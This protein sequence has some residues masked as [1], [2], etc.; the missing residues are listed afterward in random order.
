MTSTQLPGHLYGPA[1]PHIGFWHG[2]NFIGQVRGNA[3]DVEGAK[4]RLARHIRILENA[5]D[6]GRMLYQLENYTEAKIICGSSVTAIRAPSTSATLLR[7]LKDA[8]YIIDRR[9]DAG[10]QY[11]LMLVYDPLRDIV[12]GL[13][14]Q[15]GPAF[16]VGKLTFPGGKTEAGETPEEA[17]SR[18]TEEE[19]G[20]TVPVDAWRF[21]ARSSVVMVMAAVSDQVLHAKQ[22]DDEPIFVMSVPRQLEYAARNPDEYVP[23]FIVLLEAGLAT[24]G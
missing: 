6:A 5:E 23:D 16:L 1:A 3:D 4:A 24:L 19:A 11:V 17:C 18:E 12:I 15:R 2:P 9:D 8:G 13:L 7:R 10:L 20:I 21:V 14:K 22:C